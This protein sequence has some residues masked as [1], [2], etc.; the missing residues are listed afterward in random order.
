MPLGNKPRETSGMGPAFKVVRIGIKQRMAHKKYKK[1]GAKVI[2]RQ[3][4]KIQEKPDKVYTPYPPKTHFGYF[5][6]REKV[7]V[8]NIGLN[9]EETLSYMWVHDPSYKALYSYA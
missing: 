6:K 5:P 1:C 7:A 4:K 2:A 9:G 8:I 3:I